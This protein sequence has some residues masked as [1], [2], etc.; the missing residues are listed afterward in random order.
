[1]RLPH[2]LY[3]PSRFGFY[4]PLTE[5]CDRWHSE[6]LLTRL[7]NTGHEVYLIAVEYFFFVGVGGIGLLFLDTAVDSAVQETFG[8]G[9]F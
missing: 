9:T 3:S 5:H 8:S 7:S 6:V 4:K 2:P 1:M